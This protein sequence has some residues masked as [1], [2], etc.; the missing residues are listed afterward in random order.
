M[1]IEK[2]YKYI[3][4]D[5]SVCHETVRYEP[6]AFRQ[7]HTDKDG[8]VIW[9]L[10]GIEPI[11][12]RLPEITEAIRD[13]KTIFL[14]EGEKDADSL[15][16]LGFQA[17]TSPMGAGKWRDSYTFD[18]I[19]AKLCII[20]D[21]DEAGRKHL[22]LLKREL[23]PCCESIKIVTLPDGVK[24]VSDWIVGGGTKEKL[25]H[26]MEQIPIYCP[27][28]ITIPDP[29]LIQEIKNHADIIEVLR[30]Y[31]EIEEE[32]GKFKYHCTLHG[33]DRHASGVVYTDTNKAW[34]FVCDRGGDVI[35][36]VELFGKMG[37]RSAILF[38]ADYYGVNDRILP[39]RILKEKYDKYL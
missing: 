7:R 33:E 10:D 28:V 31:T 23:Y 5:G 3:N 29:N 24:D 22:A 18:L 38:L 14:V 19:G 34:C 32:N 36:I 26:I 2:V 25:E 9:N 12:Y 6:K 15:V 16:S 37:K 39:D 21:N 17:T 30:M 8:N 11:L 27:P 4:R 35:D 13:G 20:P 1:K